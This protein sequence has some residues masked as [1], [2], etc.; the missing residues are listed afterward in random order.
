MDVS[1]RRSAESFLSAYEEAASLHAVLRREDRWKVPTFGAVA[2]VNALAAGALFHGRITMM[3]LLNVGTAVYCAR[4][5]HRRLVF[6][7][8]RRRVMRPLSHAADLARRRL[9]GS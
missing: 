1:E 9:D 2:V 6:A 8:L 5:M 7:I 3:H 4:M